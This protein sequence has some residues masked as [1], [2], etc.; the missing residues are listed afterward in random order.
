M[1]TIPF[2]FYRFGVS[3]AAAPGRHALGGRLI[4][5]TAI[6]AATAALLRGV[7]LTRGSAPETLQEL[8]HT[9]SW[10]TMMRPFASSWP[11]W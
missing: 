9:S 10:S 7:A 1:F 6:Q 8:W 4:L 5:G 2:Y 11:R 3:R